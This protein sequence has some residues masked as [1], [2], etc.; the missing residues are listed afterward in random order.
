MNGSVDLNSLQW[1]LA[2]RLSLVFLIGAM[3]TV[4]GLYI[5]ATYSFETIN[6]RSLQA[7]A[8]DVVRHMSRQADGSVLVTLP[9]RVAATYDQAQGG[10]AYAIYDA[11]G[12][13]LAASRGDVASLFEDRLEGVDEEPYIRFEDAQAG[14]MYAFVSHVD[15]LKIV[16]AQG[17]WHPDVLFD[18]LVR[19]FIDESFW[20]V[21][22]IVLIVVAVGVVTVR[23]SLA[24]LRRLAER[25]ASIGPSQTDLRLPTGG[26]PSELLPMVTSVNRA[27]D[28]LDIGFESQRKFTADAA[29]EL[30]TPLSVL[31]A[32]I[33]GLPEGDGKAGLLGDV[34]RI[35]RL[36]DQLLRVARIDSNQVRPDSDLDLRALA[37]E[38]ISALAPGALRQGRELRL[39]GAKGPVIVRGDHQALLAAIINL[40]G[41]AMNHTPA[42]GGIDVTIGQDG[43]LSVRDHGKGVLPEDRQKVFRRFWRGSEAGAGGSGLG[44]SI[45]QETMAAHGGTVSV[46]DAPGGGALFVLKF[47]PAATAAATRPSRNAVPRVLAETR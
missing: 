8:S 19:E 21:A 40:I 37:A 1:R 39:L 18:S 22:I 10:L 28:R 31:T 9:E 4:A 27:L 46:D 6:D 34:W 7:Q 13:V 42:G 3:A 5:K 20:L 14:T 32:R 38:A 17:D 29:H 15:G 12:A 43:S 44:L 45:V 26:L 35:N 30:R 2:F 16:V 25:A 23:S 41:N 33:D 36:V 11:G 24:P 47:E